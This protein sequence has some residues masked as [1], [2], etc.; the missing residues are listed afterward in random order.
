MFPSWFS[1]PNG[2]KPTW[3]HLLCVCVDT[4]LKR[5]LTAL[6]P[7]SNY[8]QWVFPLFPPQTPARNQKFSDHERILILQLFKFFDLLSQ[9][10]Y[11]VGNTRTT[12]IISVHTW[13]EVHVAWSYT[14]HIFSPLLTQCCLDF[15]DSDQGAQVFEFGAVLRHTDAPHGV[16]L[17]T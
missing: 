6:P 17:F 11:P 12:F 5:N 16:S 2:P 8:V 13:I 9:K 7:A 1:Q 4:G 15:T 3:L 14:N 10:Q